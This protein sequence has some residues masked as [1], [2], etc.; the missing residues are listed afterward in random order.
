MGWVM[1][2]IPAFAA[3]FVTIAADSMV[4]PQRLADTSL[5]VQS[6]YEAALMLSSAQRLTPDQQQRLPGRL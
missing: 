4:T 6:L 1:F 5:Q 2:F 3:R